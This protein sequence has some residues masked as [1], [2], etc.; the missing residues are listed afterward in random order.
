MLEKGFR[1][2]N[3]NRFSGP[4]TDSNTIDFFQWRM[5]YATLYASYLPGGY[6]IPSIDN[7]NAISKG[8]EEDDVLPIHVLAMRYHTIKSNAFADNLLRLENNQFY[9]V[10]GRNESPYQEHTIL[11]ASPVLN[12][13]N[14]LSLRFK[15]GEVYSNITRIG[16]KHCIGIKMDFNDG[17]G[18]RFINV[19]ATY[20]VNYAEAGIKR[21][22]TMYLFSDETFLLS[23]SP[24]LVNTPAPA[25][26][27][28]TI[29]PSL[30]KSITGS[31]A[32]ESQV[33]SATLKIVYGCG[34]TKLVKP[35]IVVEGIELNEENKNEF[36]DFMVSLSN[37]GALTGTLYSELEAEGYDIVYVDYDN[38]NGRDYIQRNAY[39]LEEAIKWVNAEK[40]RNGSIEKNVVMGI[41]MG[42]LVAR[43]ALRNMEK[44]GLNHDAKKY[45]SFDTPHQG[46]N[47]PLGLQ[48]ML[49][50]IANTTVNVLF[51][52]PFK[53]SSV[54]S[55][56][57]D[58]Y[59][60]L[61]SVAAK[62]MLVLHT[63][64]V[65]SER[66]QLNNEFTA[67]GNNGFPANCDVEFIANGSYVGN[68]QGFPDLQSIVKLSSSINVQVKEIKVTPGKRFFGKLINA[69]V[70]FVLEYTSVG[71]VELE[72]F[73]LPAKS[74]NSDKI[75]YEGH[76]YAIIALVNTTLTSRVDWNPSHTPTYDN[77]QGGSFNIAVFADD[78]P[79]GTNVKI[80]RFCFV[81]TTSSLNIRYPE[82]EDLNARY[83][84]ATITTNGLTNA[85][86]VTAEDSPPVPNRN[87][88]SHTAFSARNARFLADDLVL[89]RFAGG[90]IFNQVY[91]FGSATD[92]RIG[93]STTLFSNGIVYINRNMAMGTGNLPFPQVNSSCF[94]TTQ[95]C[96]NEPVQITIA[97]A[98]LL[99][100]GD[101][102]NSSGYRGQ[103]N[104][105]TGSSLAIQNGGTLRINNHSTLGIDAGAS[106]T[107]EAGSVI[108]LGGTNANI[109]LNGLV[110]FPQNGIVTIRGAGIVWVYSNV[111]MPTGCTLK[112]ENG[113]RV[114][115]SASSSYTHNKGVKLE[116]NNS[117][118]YLQF[119]DNSKLIIPTG[120]TFG[121]T[122]SGYILW[123]TTQAVQSADGS[124]M[125]LEGTGPYDQILYVVKDRPLYFS[126]GNRLFLM[127]G[128][129]ELG[130]NAFVSCSK[131]GTFRDLQIMPASG[132][133]SLSHQGL[134]LSGPDPK[135]VSNVLITEGK[136]GLRLSGAGRATAYT[137]SSS[138]FTYNDIGV[139]ST[140]T[141]VRFDNC[142]FDNNRI[143][144]DAQATS[145][146]SVLENS[147]LYDNKSNI[148]TGR[149]LHFTGSFASSLTLSNTTVQDN[150]I[151]ADVY[152]LVDT[153]IKCAMVQDNNVGIK[154]SNQAIFDATTVGGTGQSEFAYNKRSVEFVNAFYPQL[155]L[156]QNN[157]YRNI[158]QYHFYG[159]IQDFT[160]T[161]FNPV[162]R[163]LQQVITGPSP[164]NLAAAKIPAELNKWCGVNASG[165]Y[166]GI[167][168]FSDDYLTYYGIDQ[169]PNKKA[170]FDI[171]T[172][173]YSS[174]SCEVSIPCPPGSVVSPN[175]LPCAGELN[176]NCLSCDVVVTPSFKGLQTNQVF[177]Q[178]LSAQTKTASTQDM[179]KVSNQ[180]ME[181]LTA[182]LVSPDVNDI[183]I[184]RRAYSAM[185]H[186]A[187]EW[188]IQEGNTAATQ[189]AISNAI[190]VINHLVKKQQRYLLAEPMLL[191]IDKAVLYKMQGNLA[192]ALATITAAKSNYPNSSNIAYANYWECVFSSEQKLVNGELSTTEYFETVKNCTYPVLAS[193]PDLASKLAKNQEKEFSVAVADLSLEVYPNP[194]NMDDVAR[195]LLSLPEETNAS[196]SVY[197]IRG[198]KVKQIASNSK[199]MA[200]VNTL[201]LEQSDLSN[202]IYYLAVDLP[203][204]Q[205]KS[206]MVVLK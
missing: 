98:G 142:T 48:H 205:L 99:E 206:K 11:A 157:F 184:L 139:F 127:N 63:H 106:F 22:K 176:F 16:D 55:D 79:P 43:Y 137:I 140:G 52:I 195:I 168:A 158:S 67:L 143:G 126:N 84:P 159:Y 191:Q 20:A 111:I 197:D 116:L 141:G 110:N 113:A 74:N 175:G 147:S 104:V 23:H 64:G 7:L 154:L 92:N 62:Q 19:G 172:A 81:P 27:Y 70:S 13:V 30:T 53:L 14:T 166:C 122:G 91:N 133:P 170:E 83:D 189:L 146:P 34:H 105:T 108:E 155:N 39:M 123:S 1:L 167:P 136:Y 152:G 24:L 44:R 153:R 78:L 46:A 164:V 41:S 188:V 65:Q 28:S 198:K 88:G 119:N 203:N 72:A 151:G 181:L 150:D 37:A 94:V 171:K 182:N 161:V 5:T 138:T 173:T 124:S 107:L 163:T 179:V 40:A 169:L 125:R 80:D 36:S 144:W 95:S 31:I 131:A 10:A 101:A 82:R 56:V 76:I 128:T 6:P 193:L 4:L 93:S 17:L 29:E 66:K 25:N 58:A 69:L 32:Y 134:V 50:H 35:F 156:G 178:I 109:Y 96:D 8:I 86:R 18:Y 38:D 47:V 60:M 120:Q 165:Y 177:N 97:N 26:R 183:A 149:G 85:K 42:G 204:R 61:T 49:D 200:G 33:N 180:Y 190:E 90:N 68:G 71:F 102:V 15:L 162:T 187:G 186:L 54:I 2:T 73:A 77:A 3:V 100:L 57:G 21:I 9:D 115:M 135:L 114:V 160:G 51:V 59:D 199:F 201:L 112:L 145:L 12:E 192:S 45:I 118:S 196:I 117:Y 103:L 202:G 87:N 121:Y 130:E 148:D 185:L 75:I 194:L 129:V 174:F 132:T 89:P